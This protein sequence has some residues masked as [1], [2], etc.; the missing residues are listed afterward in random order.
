MKVHKE[1]TMKLFR[2]T[3]TLQRVLALALGATLLVACGGGADRTKAQ[4][5][6][7]NASSGYASLDL[8]VD[9]ELRQGAVSPG[10]SAAYVEADP[11]KAFTLHVAGSGTSLLSFTPSVSAR[12]YYSVL[13]Y[14]SL[15]ALKQ[16]VLDDNAGA[17]D[18]NRALLRVV[19]AAPDAGALDVYLTGTDDS[20]A[21][22]VPQ[23][24]AAAVDAVGAWLTV[25]SGSYRL[26]VTAAGSK[27]DLRL[28]VPALA[29]ASRQV[30]TLVIS[31][32]SGGVLV[33]GLLLS[34][35]AEITPQAATQARVRVAS[36]LSDA[37]IASLRLGGTAI[38][39]NVTAPAVTG[40]TLVPAGEQAVVVG[41][42]AATLP[43][44]TRTLVVGA[45]Y[46]VLV[47]GSPAAP[48][49]AW[50]NDNNTLPSDRA[51]A[52]I[53]LVNGL[54][55]LPGNLSMSADFTPVAD[56]VA[57]GAASAYDLIDATT[58]GRLS[59]TAAGVALPLF[60][61]GEQSFAAAAN[62][63]VFLVGSPTAPVGIVR[64]D[65]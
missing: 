64:K 11:G 49:V 24:A 48:V 21:A 57:A 26:R 6:L 19:N 36:G 47:Y 2:R 8:R 63:T 43:S 34:Q 1:V 25:N 17:P 38:F 12:R 55:G 58:T 61:I 59:V 39:A 42:N 15:G 37:G 45:D 40:Y 32:T 14:G 13:A 18:N 46:T 56:N 4:V 7:V 33:Q 9:N 60:G 31:P 54:A 51:R 62:Y 27:T 52:K 35:Q 30:A 10:N 3:L 44:D 20:L 28:D 41:V 22:S 53:R 50:V 16:L 5:R 23:Q 29:L 65:R